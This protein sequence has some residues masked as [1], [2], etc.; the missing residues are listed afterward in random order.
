[1]SLR[2][3]R[4]SL[5]GACHRPQ[6]AT[7]RRG[8]DGVFRAPEWLCPVRLELPAANGT[9]QVRAIAEAYGVAATRGPGVW[10]DRVHPRRTGA[11]SDTAERWSARRDLAPRLRVFARVRQTVCFRF[12]ASGGQA[13]GTPGAGGSFGFA[14]PETGIGFAYAMNRT[15]FRLWDDPREVA[16]RDAL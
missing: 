13:F 6:D 3:P 9:S 12:G 5:P 4:P 8:V 10:S 16:L 11:P 15:G 7:G 1:M 14:D 2:S